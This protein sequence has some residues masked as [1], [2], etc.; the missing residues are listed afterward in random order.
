[1]SS[2]RLVLA[3]D[4]PVDLQTHTILSDGKW[5][6]EKL[7][8]H[9]V[10]EGFALAAITDHDRV[11]TADMLQKLAQDHQFFLLRAT[12][13]TTIWQDKMVDVLCYGFDTNPQPLDD[14]TQDIRHRQQENTREVY[15]NLC[16][17][18]Y[19][20]KH[21][22][23]ELNV[24]LEIPSAQQVKELL[25][26]VQKY[27]EGLSEQLSGKILHEAGFSFATHETA[28]VVDK[29]HQSGAVALIAHP[30]RSEGFLTFDAKILDQLRED[31]PIDGIEAYYPL[32]TPEQVELFQAYADEHDLLVSSGSDSHTPEKPP[33]KYHAELNRKLLERLGLEVLKA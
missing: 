26:L 14:L 4:A 31:I 2:S 5:I 28:K 32:H 3:P 10:S 18:G 30:G 24:I 9:F 13:M 8:Q 27:N 25:D 15:D 33:I 17:A 6:P 21:D 11:D 23:D 20:S 7:I 19:V 16:K 1:M 29:A 12:E 22:A